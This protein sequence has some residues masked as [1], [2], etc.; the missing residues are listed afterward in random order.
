LQQKENKTML[1]TDLIAVALGKRPADLVVKNAKIV[2]VHTRE[3]YS[4]GVA[5]VGERIALIGD[6]D[7]AIGPQTKVVDAQGKH[8]IPAFIDAHIHVESTLLTPT[9]FAKAVLPRGTGAVSTDLMEVTL[10]AGVSGLKEILEEARHTPVGFFYMVPS[11]M[12]E[13]ELQT[14]GGL[15]GPELVDELIDL[16]EAVGLAEVLA[17]PILAESPMSAHMIQ[18]ATQ[19][20]KTRE[21]HG[22]ALFGERMQAY[23]GAGITSEHESTTAEEALA[24]LRS[25][26]RVLI[27]EGSAST[28]LKPVIKIVTEHGVDPRHV[29]LVSD[30]ID[31]LH[32]TQLGHMDHKIRMAVAE[33]VEPI[34]AI[35]M[36]TLN[37][38]ESLRIDE[39]WGSLAP[40]KYASMSILSGDLAQCQVETVIAKGKVVYQNNQLVAELPPVKYSEQLVNTV[41]LARPL[42]AE[43]MLIKL[44]KPVS[45][46]RVRV[47]GASGVT[48][49]KEAQEADLPVVD[50][51]I[52]PDPK[53]DIL[54][55]ACVERYE[56]SGRIGKAFAS[57][58]GLKAGALASSVGHDHHNITVVGAS[59]ADMAVAVNRIAEMG[60]GLVVV[61]DGRV[62]GE[63]AL[64]ICGLVTAEP[65]G[66]VAEKVDKM[67][68]A[69]NELGCQMSNPFM[70]LSFITLIYIPAYGITDRG[71]V[72]FTEFE[73]V[74]SIMETK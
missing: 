22:P 51:V 33:G 27:R 39:D 56:K 58:F 48:L 71:L 73:V 65:A 38:A 12:E 14:V 55:V 53:N 68:H 30:D 5:V 24:K 11:F 45:G 23:A 31:A 13:S 43:D 69:L 35:Q 10:V 42:T 64:P 1:Q 59:T 60:G 28:D 63:L 41:H 8:L 26:L 18:M 6:V 72:E 62:L 2:N 47:L 54:A 52:Q 50:G 67:N 19:K 32:I 21:G 74:D 57:G 61:R 34:V 49:L 40:G 66:T 70:T 3:I 37:P 16:P 15:L 7:K 4:G 44:D 46:V 17:P 36:A 20:R 29:G 9:E 25:G